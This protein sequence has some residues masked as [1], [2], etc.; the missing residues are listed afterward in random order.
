[1]AGPWGGWVADRDRR[2]GELLVAGRVLQDDVVGA[3]A[4]QVGI[5]EVVVAV[6]HAVGREHALGQ[7]GAV[8]PGDPDGVDRVGRTALEGDLAVDEARRAGLAG[9]VHDREHVRAGAAPGEALAAVV[10]G[11]R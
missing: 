6:A 2:G 8:G 9:G 7:A 10:A 3:A 5:V 4:H 1:M 11:L